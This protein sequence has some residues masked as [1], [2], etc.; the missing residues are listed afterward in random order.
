[1]CGDALLLKLSNRYPEDQ[2]A[3]AGE[4][5]L[6][7]KRNGD[8][9]VCIAEAGAIPLLVELLSSPD[10][11]TQEH[12]VT[13]LLNLSINETNKVNE[14]LAILAIL[15]SY[16]EGRVAI[17]QAEP[18]PVLVETRQRYKRRSSLGSIKS[19][20]KGFGLKTSSFRVSAMAMYEV[21]FIGPDGDE[22]EFELGYLLY[23]GLR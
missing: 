23:P 9:R 5:R 6:L 13:T 11:R 2:R 18:T 19:V 20:S 21:K 22:N 14:A 17:G 8:N 15:A 1:M 16:Q 4:L 12:A 10:S 3:A 7:A